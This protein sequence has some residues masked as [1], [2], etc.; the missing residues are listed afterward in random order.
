[1]R[2]CPPVLGY[3]ILATST[4]W[5][6][7]ATMGVATARQTV[8]VFLATST[9]W[10]RVA[11]QRV[12]TMGCDFNDVGIRLLPFLVHDDKFNWQR[13]R[14]AVHVGSQVEPTG[15]WTCDWGSSDED[16]AG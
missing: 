2:R 13:C 16:F 11:T 14:I 1:M 6:R 15:L 7:V 3:R 4:A 12:A 9:A 10:Q 5:Q 8:V